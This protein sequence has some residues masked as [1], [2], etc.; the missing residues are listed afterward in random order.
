MEALTWKSFISAPVPRI[1]LTPFLLQIRMSM[2]RA[3]KCY[4]GLRR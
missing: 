4:S 3:I 1:H 2:C